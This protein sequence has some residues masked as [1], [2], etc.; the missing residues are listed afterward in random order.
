MEILRILLCWAISIL[1]MFNLYPGPVAGNT[2]VLDDSEQPVL[3]FVVCSDIHIKDSRDTREYERLEKLF[4]YSYRYAESKPYS[5]IDAFVFVGD[6]IDTGTKVQADYLNEIVGNYKDPETPLL[7]VYDNHDVWNNGTVAQCEE[8]FGI[9]GNEDRVINGFHFITV[10]YD[11]ANK[12]YAHRLPSLFRQ[13]S[14]AKR[15]DPQKPVFVFNHRHITGTVYGSDSWGTPEL[16]PVLNLFPQV[17]N[18]SG[19]SHYAINDPRSCHQYFFTSFN[20]GTL[21]YL[22]QEKGMSYGSVPPGAANVA[23]FYIVEVFADNSVAVLP[24]NIITGDFFKV[25]SS[26][27]DGQLIYYIT[28]P[29]DRSGFSYTTK[30]YQ[31]ADRPVWPADAT[32]EFTDVTANQATLSFPQALDGEEIHQYR[33][34]L[35][36]GLTVVGTYRFWSEFYF[37]PMPETVSWTFNDLKPDT[38]YTVIITGFDTYMN[39]TLRP[40]TASFTTAAE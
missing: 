2:V 23:G 9:P 21:S 33:V 1:S 26:Y 7:C 31:T 10:S 15:E 5:S 32:P 22:E 24:F 36:K 14:N 25:P 18:F 34:V 8:W 13:L 6:I 30:R 35:M 17:I 37:E 3:R 40:L 28:N 4:E 11:D 20:C 27:E 38:K 39:S 19:H 29:S 12:S 16:S